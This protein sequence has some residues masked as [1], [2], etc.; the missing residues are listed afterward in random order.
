MKNILRLGSAG[1][2]ML[3]AILISLFAVAS[4]FG[5]ETSGSVEGTV[6]DAS[7]ARVPGATVKIEGAA[8]T[9][10]ATTNNDGF[11]RVLQIPPGIYKVSVNASNFSSATAEAVT[12]LLGKATEVD[13]S[14]KVGQVQ[15]QVVITSDDVARIDPTD[16]K[17]QTNI[18]AKQLETLPKGTNFTSLLKLSPAVRQEPLS[19]Q[20][21][22][23]G[24]SG[25]ENSFIIDGQEV[26]NFRTGI[27]NTNNNLPFAFV[28]EMQIKTS[29]FEAQFGGATGGVINVVTKGGSNEFHGELSYQW[30]PSS[31]WAGP[32][33]V[34]QGFRGAIDTS[35]SATGA[36]FI[37]INNYIRGQRDEFVNHYPAGTISGP[38]VKDRLWFLGS[39]APQHLNTTRNAVYVTSDPRNRSVTARDTYKTRVTNEYAFARLD[40]API[41]SLRLSGAYTWNPIVQDGIIPASSSGNTYVGGSPPTANFSSVGT[42]RG[43]DLTN[44][45]GGRQNSNNVTFS[46]VWTP[47]SKLV[48]SFRF[49]RGFLNEK[50]N[51]YFIPSE[52]RFVC[53]GTQPPP[54]AGCALGFANLPVNGN[55]QISFDASVRRN[56]DADASYLVGSL[57]GRHEFKGGYQH[58]KLTNDVLNGYIPFGVVSLSY[59]QTI[60]DLTGRNDAV[61]PGSIG[62][63]SLTRI[64]VQ[65]SASNTAQSIY[66]QDKWQPISRL[67]INVGVRFE[68]ED[69]PSFNGFA[70]PINFGWG[71]K[72][73]P[74]LGAAYDLFGDGRTKLFASFGRFND[75]LKFELPRGS[76][77]GDFFRRDYFEIS[78]SN[79]RYDYYTLPRI[80]GNNTDI[81]N[82]KCPINNPSGLTRCQYDFRIASNNPGA[83]IE[84]GKVDP[85]LK[86]FRQTEFTVGMEREFARNWLMSARYTYKNVDS[87]VEDAGFP[88][89]QGSEAY[90]IGN[91]GS[92]LHAAAA[93]QFGYV[94]TTT[95][96]RRYDAFEI[97]VDRR[98]TTNYFINMAYTYSR[99]FGNY[100][101]LSSSDENGRNSPGVNRFFDLPHLGFTAAGIPD[102]G[103]LATDRPH[104][105][106]AFGGYDFKWF[107]KVKNN[108]TLFSFFTTFQSGTPLTSF[109]TFYATS[110]LNG[111]GDLGRSPMFTQTDFNLTHTVRFTE[112]FRLAFDFNV[113][114]LFNEANVLGVSNTPSSVGTS[115]A[116]LKLPSN[117]TTE[118]QA[119]NYVLTN[120][121][122]SNFNA[123]VN[124]P[125]A[126]ER[127]NTGY[128][129]DNNWQGGRAI[130][131]AFRF[132][133]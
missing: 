132:N 98:F 62:A 120:G 68:K 84:D 95:P 79:P 131:F 85:D 48:T 47:T 1:K 59:G 63:G 43:S 87:A 115:I 69:L 42:L 82:G 27:L 58:S 37:Q 2:L 6:S 99:L 55:R 92:G 77:G 50:L 114:N 17:I 83:A 21:Q 106:N 16:N 15:E 75:R 102:N 57:A 61:T 34:F 101:G 18:T 112:R 96:Q 113:I 100:S 56:F 29:G 88:T 22:V 123:F 64:G 91:P 89:A 105:F 36:N 133:F 46:A 11:Y 119:I 116:G 107:E 124:D 127:K 20:F 30:E 65:G 121:I 117:V 76:F 60:N 72:I 25:S 12:V 33:Q 8:F 70:P 93:K 111:R 38:V 14:L 9:R 128:R 24:A 66:I 3:C 51:S 35:K 86:P 118:P 41:D 10:S 32:R 52:T 78:P 81:I 94:K 122:T 104:V 130:R 73:A 71:D 4:A 53:G 109:Y 90:I 7:G 97:R 125:A 67:S 45:Q 13:F 40:A 39:Y 103:R 54:G 108:A 74:R 26:N 5:Q 28:Q 129:F 110:I 31:A 126:P 80:L 19:G 23:D 44:R 49:S